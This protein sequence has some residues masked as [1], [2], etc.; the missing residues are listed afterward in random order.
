M[1]K[2]FTKLLYIG[3]DAN[4]SYSYQVITLNFIAIL[5]AVFSIA[6]GCVFFHFTGEYRIL[7]P[8]VLEGL[9]FLCILPLHH[10]GYYTGAKIN[11]QLT[12]TAATVY[13]GIILTEAVDASLL[14]AF[15]AGQAFLLFP[16]EKEGRLRTF[17]LA[18][19]GLSYV[20]L[21]V[22][23][24]FN[25]VEPLHFDHTSYLWVHIAGGVV[26]I[27]LTIFII[28]RYQRI[29]ERL[30][31]DKSNLLEEIKQQNENL[32]GVVKQ[33]T[34]ELENAN[35]SI[36][37]YL[38]EI[39]HEIRT[40]LNSIYYAS[41]MVKEGI[42][43][44]VQHVNDIVLSRSLLALRI[45]NNILTIEKLSKGDY[46]AISN[47]CFLLQ[48]FLLESQQAAQIIANE[49]QVTIQLRT[50]NIPEAIVSDPLNL[51]KVLNNLLLNAIKFTES[52]ST[53]YLDAT[54]EHNQL[55][56]SVADQGKGIPEDILPHIFNRVN[57]G[58][59]RFIEGNGLGLNLV[60]RIVE[61]FNGTITVQSSS[62]GTVFTVRVPMKQ[63]DKQDIKVKPDEEIITCNLEGT[64]VLVI[65]DEL[66]AQKY[67]EIVLSK[68]GCDFT[69]CSNFE[70]AHAHALQVTPGIIVL[71][72][73]LPGKKGPDIIKDFKRN[74]RFA[75]IPIIVMS[76]NAFHEEIEAIKGLGVN[77]YIV[78]PDS[79]HLLEK[80]LV[81]CKK[82]IF[83][84]EVLENFK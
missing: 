58:T 70:D 29:T 11:A 1:K 47:E 21:E 59:N 49:R 39:S 48:E 69:I 24:Q 57:K 10:K 46:L 23:K 52:K 50:R 27:V 76:S 75:S 20:I 55:V 74:P 31:S 6:L 28:A 66:M 44:E 51:D 34:Q 63:G 38:R 64:K 3:T 84:K 62:K 83:A 78:K 12:H 56:L 80:A 73:T 60:K 65:E 53:I 45:I 81:K 26:I 8:T 35:N 42:T 82:I 16:L 67:V 79:T 30:T 37:L 18:I 41:K 7:I 68:L 43:H 32:E 40:P 61:L 2:L 5:T 72:L 36:I 77:E 9:S 4:P 22:V 13:F 15:L 54:V 19:A 14:V 33:R 25:L 71:D 17:C